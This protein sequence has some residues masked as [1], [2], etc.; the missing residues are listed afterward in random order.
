MTKKS[1]I[2][3]ILLVG[4]SFLGGT[5][6]GFKSGW[7]AAI[8]V[9]IVAEA[10]LSTT[11]HKILMTGDIPPV[12]SLFNHRI[13]YGID[14]YL[15]LQENENSILNRLFLFHSS[16]QNEAYMNRIAEFRK[17]V[18]AGDSGELLAGEI[19]REYMLKLEKRNK[20]LI[21]RG[22][23]IAALTSSGN[24]DSH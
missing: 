16:S 20:E 18:P 6:Y 5:V 3:A 10:A 2:V 22:V 9:E 17:T 14:S 23:P 19:Q 7:E 24:R 1:Y 12:E 11:M 21:R 4:T 15:W 8:N 13:D